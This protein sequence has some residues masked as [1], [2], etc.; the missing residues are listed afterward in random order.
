MDQ[1][2]LVL[3]IL[4]LSHDEYGIQVCLVHE[5]MFSRHVCESPEV[6]SEI[7]GGV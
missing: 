7:I 6:L 1:L 5:H 4:I 2:W 3:I